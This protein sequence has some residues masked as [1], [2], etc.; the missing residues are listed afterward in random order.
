MNQHS[1]KQTSVISGV[2]ISIFPKKR[3]LRLHLS[4]LTEEFV[5]IRKRKGVPLMYRSQFPKGSAPHI[6]SMEGGIIRFLRIEF[7]YGPLMARTV[8]HNHG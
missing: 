6:R 8:G 1:S 5:L 3:S 4:V 2:F 7:V